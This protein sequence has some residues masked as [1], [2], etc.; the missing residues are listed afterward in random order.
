MN[1]AVLA[2][3][4][5]QAQGTRS[6]ATLAG[7]ALAVASIV[8]LIGL[9]RGVETTL[10]RAFDVRGTDAIVTEAGALDLASSLVNESLA[11]EIAV[12]PGVMAAAAE[13]TRMTSLESGATVFVTAWP[14]DAHPWQALDVLEGA[15]PPA[16][17]QDMVAIGEGIANRLGL[18][19]GDKVSLFQTQFTVGG[20]VGSRSLL[21]QNLVYLDLSIAQRL[22]YR[23]GLATAI[24]VRL[25]PNTPPSNKK[26]T[27]ETLEKAF[28]NYAIAETEQLAGEYVYSKIANAFAAAITFVTLI[29]AVLAIYNTMNM[30]VNERRAEIAVMKAVGWSR[31]RIMSSLLLEGV[32][33]T[34][35]AGII[36]CLMGT[37]V[38][39]I[40]SRSDLIVSLIVPDISAEL[41]VQAGLISLVIGIAGTLMPALHAVRSFP[42]D[43]L[44]GR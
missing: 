8:A 31:G 3:R 21:M 34:A 4:N 15:L 1:L 2:W 12:V 41:L 16:S 11:Q 22:T 6:F 38:A 20:I 40:V 39:H 9:A 10:K 36:G 42:A 27:V 35:V 37:I 17:G 24:N 14:P 33:L 23:E 26:A 32:A 19:I 25:D 7:I 43:I 28:P 30:A 44:R 29:G 5:V 13:L 18:T